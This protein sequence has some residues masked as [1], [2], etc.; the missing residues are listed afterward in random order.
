MKWREKD[1]ENRQ[2]IE[3]TTSRPETG[4]EESLGVSINALGGEKK[5]KSSGIRRKRGEIVES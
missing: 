2:K 5:G 4:V 3:R 1:G